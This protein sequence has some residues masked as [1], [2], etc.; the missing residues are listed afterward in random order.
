VKSRILRGRRVLRELLKPLHANPRVA[1]AAA[2]QEIRHAA[3]AQHQS[4]AILHSPLFAS[5]KEETCSQTDTQGWAESAELGD[6]E[7]GV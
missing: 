5:V 7:E 4:E 1:H 6:V 2:S 3:G